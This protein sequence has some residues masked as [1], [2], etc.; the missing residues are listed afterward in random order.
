MSIPNFCGGLL[1]ETKMAQPPGDLPLFTWASTH[2]H[3]TDPET[4]TQA[5]I[6]VEATAKGDALKILEVFK[7]F[8]LLTADEAAEKLGWQDVYK[9]R[10][11]CSDLKNKGLIVD[12][13]ERRPSSNGN[14]S[15]VWRVVEAF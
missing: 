6:K 13:G 10:R 9:A 14:P 8:G 15:V 5:A 4:S 3:K 12:S 2:T 1:E 11:R 7:R